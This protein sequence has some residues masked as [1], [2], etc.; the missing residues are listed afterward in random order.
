MLTSFKSYVEIYIY[1]Y[2]CISLRHVQLLLSTIYRCNYN[3]LCKEEESLV[4]WDCLARH[5]TWAGRHLSQGS[6]TRRHDGQSNC[7]R[8]WLLWLIG[9]P[10]TWARAGQLAATATSTVNGFTSAAAASAATFTN[11]LWRISNPI[12]SR[13][14]NGIS[15]MI[16]K[17][18][19]PRDTHGKL[20]C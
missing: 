8:T 6:G 9:A 3:T 11:S 14:A 4:K 5:I 17:E 12:E 1:I 20:K 18:T 10:L 7:N 15:I 13:L 16:R 2:I 19:W